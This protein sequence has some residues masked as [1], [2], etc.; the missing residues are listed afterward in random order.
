VG[1][2]ACISFCKF[3]AFQLLPPYHHGILVPKSGSFFFFWGWRIP[4]VITGLG[5]WRAPDKSHRPK[6]LSLPVAILFHGRPAVGKDSLHVSRRAPFR[7]TQSM[8]HVHCLIAWFQEII[9]RSVQ[10]QKICSAGCKAPGSDPPH[11]IMRYCV[12]LLLILVAFCI[13]TRP[14]WSGGNVLY[15]LGT[16][17]QRAN[18]QGR[19]FN[20]FTWFLGSDGHRALH[21]LVVRETSLL[22]P[23]RP[24]IHASPH[25]GVCRLACILGL[26]DRNN[27]VS[28]ATK[29]CGAQWNGAPPLVYWP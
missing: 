13:S 5:G 16:S 7:P 25:T 29:E 23:V 22:R 28:P 8:I 12:Y 18:L 27:G 21:S 9:Y 24:R 17:S 14:N 20:M 15:D 1:S 6:K 26:T 19:P 3:G 11:K 2:L 4:N 10:I